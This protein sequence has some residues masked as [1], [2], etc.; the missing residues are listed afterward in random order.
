MTRNCVCASAVDTPANV[1]SLI[2]SLNQ[3]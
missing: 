1:Y 3:E 2:V